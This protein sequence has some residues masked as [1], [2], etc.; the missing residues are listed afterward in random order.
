MPLQGKDPCAENESWSLLGEV[1]WIPGTR[2]ADRPCQRDDCVVRLHYYSLVKVVAS[3]GESLP[4]G[5][6]Q[7]CHRSRC[8]QDRQLDTGQVS[9]REKYP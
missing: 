1:L 9:Y 5:I 4:R 6:A 8:L 2:T 7:D 3:P